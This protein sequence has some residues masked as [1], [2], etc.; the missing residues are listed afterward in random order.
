MTVKPSPICTLSEDG[1][2]LLISLPEGSFEASDIPE[3]RQKI[4]A[5]WNSSIQQVRFDFSRVTLIDSAAIGAILGVYRRL[6][7]DTNPV[8]IEQP[9]AAIRATLNLFRLDEVLDLE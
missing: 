9:N 5:I 4:N 7:H 8:K 1:T 3:F 2:S 6:A